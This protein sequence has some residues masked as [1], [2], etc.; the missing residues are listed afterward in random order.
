[1]IGIY[2]ESGLFQVCS[3]C[4]PVCS[5]AWNVEKTVCSWS[6]PG[7]F[8]WLLHT[9]LF[10]QKT[11]HLG[12]IPA[13]SQQLALENAHPR[14]CGRCAKFTRISYPPDSD[15]YEIRVNI[16]HSGEGALGLQGLSGKAS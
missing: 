16:Q 4:V 2:N 8:L 1:M 12:S 15:R 9:K 11:M 5:E 7:L 14:L 13:P 3:E 6:V 10:S